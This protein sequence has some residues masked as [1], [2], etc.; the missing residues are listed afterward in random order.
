MDYAS[1]SLKMMGIDTMTVDILNSNAIFSLED[2]VN[3]SKYEISKMDGIG[4][5][6]YRKIID[7]MSKYGVSPSE[8]TEGLSPLEKF[9]HEYNKAL[10]SLK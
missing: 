2:L 4:S 9:I 6:R 8:S 7:C 10:D 1:I 5:S 3:T